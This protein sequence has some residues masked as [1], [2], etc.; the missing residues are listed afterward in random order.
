MTVLRPA[1]TATLCLVCSE[2]LL[3]LVFRDDCG[4]APRVII[5]VFAVALIC[6]ITSNYVIQY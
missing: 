1:S 6:K 4:A 2:Y 5:V 3:A